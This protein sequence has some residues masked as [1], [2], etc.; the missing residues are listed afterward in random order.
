MPL[1]TVSI[2]AKVRN[3]YIFDGDENDIE[4]SARL[5]VCNKCGAF[6]FFGLAFFLLFF[7]QTRTLPQY[8]PAQA[9]VGAG[10]LG[11]GWLF[12]PL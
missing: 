11:I 8:E 3:F 4:E 10:K 1:T 6:L 9:D 12:L 7:P 5:P 2:G